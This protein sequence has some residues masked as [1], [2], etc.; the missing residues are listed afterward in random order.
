MRSAISTQQLRNESSEKD[1]EIAEMRRLITDLPTA[2]RASAC[3]VED[4]QRELEQLRESNQAIQAEKSAIQAEKSALQQQLADQEA[5]TR[6][7]TD[8]NERQ[9][10]E[11]MRLLQLM[12]QRDE[13]NKQLQTAL[14]EQEHLAAQKQREANELQ[15]EITRMASQLDDKERQLQQKEEELD[16]KKN[17]IEQQGS[18]IEQQG[19]T[20]EEQ[21]RRMNV[22]RHEVQEK[23]TANERLARDLQRSESAVQELQQLQHQYDSVTLIHDDSLHMTGLKLGEGAYGEVGVG[24]W[25]GVGVAVK[26][27]HEEPVRVDELNISFIRR[28][29]SVSSRVHHPN[30]VS[31]CGAIIENEV[32]LRIVMELL[33]GSLKD[34]IKAALKSRYLSMR[35]QVDVAVGCLCGVMYLHHLQPALLHGDIRSTNILISKTMQAKIG[36]LGS[37]RFSNESLS[38]GPL[39]P[40][41]IAPERVV[42]GRAVTPR[43]TTQAD[44]YSLGVTF[45]E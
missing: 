44:M 39:S 36:D 32:P 13:D 8:E 27:F 45:V 25:S 43:N 40:Q 12:Q 18:T 11:L 1:K 6:T 26:T 9:V 31:I 38:V 23:Q 17:T 4:L 33:E 16:G 30:V 29:V 10:G 41:Y 21:R 34:V 28:E 35:E 15:E 19:S 24:M 5:V 42:E 22:L 7:V 2:L 20:I 37:C 3:Q 14:H